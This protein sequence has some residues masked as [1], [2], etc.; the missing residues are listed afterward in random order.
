MPCLYLSSLKYFY[1]FIHTLPLHFGLTHLSAD[2]RYFIKCDG[3][4]ADE[5][6]ILSILITLPA[7]SIKDG[8]SKLRSCTN[9]L[10]SGLF[11]RLSSFKF[12]ATISWGRVDSLLLCRLSERSFL[13][14][15]NVGGRLCSWL[16]QRTREVIRCNVPSSAGTSCKALPP[17][18][19]TSN[20][21][22]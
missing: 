3:R 10:T 11:L 9:L 19:S 20:L 18:Y 1:K 21:K 12:K 13:R 17:K 4:S 16:S 22:F 15:E 6:L 2:D 8:G 5:Y 7:S 14:C